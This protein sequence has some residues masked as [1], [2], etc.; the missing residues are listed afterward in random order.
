MSLVDKPEQVDTSLRA[1]G[2]QHSYLVL[3]L[4]ERAKG[5]V[6]PYRDSYV[7]VG[8]TIC[9]KVADLA[10]PLPDGRVAHVCVCNPGHD[11][12]CSAWTAVDSQGLDQLKSTGKLGGCGTVTRM[13][14]A[15]AETYARDPSFYGGTFCSGCRAHLPVGEEGQFVWLDGSRVGT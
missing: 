7:H 14:R 15:L 2:Q 6:R 11:G 5:F 10:S 9:G 4:E 8:R 3:S 12:E 1:D 13:A